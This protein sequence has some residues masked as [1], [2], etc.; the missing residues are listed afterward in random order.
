MRR[1]A[2]A[3]LTL[4]LYA[5]RDNGTL[6]FKNVIVPIDLFDMVY[7]SKNETMDLSTDK[8]FLPNDKRNTV[9]KAISLMKEKYNINDNFKVHIVK[10]I[11]AQ[12]GLGGGS[13]DA[14]SVIHMLDE[15]YDLKMSLEDKIDIAKEIDEDTPFCIL[16]T[17]ASVK[18]IGEELE[19]IDCE[20]DLYYLLVKPK[21]GVSTKSFLKNFDED[22]SANENN[23]ELMIEACRKNDYKQIIELRHNSFQ[24]AVINR[25]NDIRDL[26][27][28]LDEMGLDGVGMT[29]SGSSVYGLA[30]DKET[31]R[32]V[33]EEL[34]F[35]YP[36]VKYGKVLK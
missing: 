12:S 36:F 31:V 29:G 18:G 21:F 28:R 25:Y 19:A 30:S 16:S 5:Y 23:M 2:F 33:F 34:V 35:D 7:L 15:L 14:A 22:D 32:K 6:K 9:Y 10:N 8:R 17:L 11:P 3:K 13:S 20:L 24:N 26:I 1:K 4:S 27:N